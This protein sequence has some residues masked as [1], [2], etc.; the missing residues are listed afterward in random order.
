VIDAERSSREPGLPADRCLADAQRQRL[1]ELFEQ[2]PAS[3][4]VV[5]GDDLVFEMVNRHYARSTR[6]RD[7]LI[8]RRALDAFPQLRDRGLKQMIALVRCTG[9][10]C[11]VRELA[12]DDRW[13]SCVLAPLPG[14][15][16]EIDRVMSLAYEVTEL[17]RACAE[18]EHALE[19]SE[20]L[21]AMLGDDLRHP[22]DAIAADA[23][24]VQRVAADLELGSPAVRIVDA[25]EQIS[26]RIAQLLDLARSAASAWGCRSDQ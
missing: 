26:R 3:I 4:A 9:E 13:W 20:K 24:R 23:R 7:D 19:S 11:V 6:R 22:L 5:R 16:G 10:P 17:V 21:T 2:A 25:A 12:V 8:G 15:R 1:Y 14:E 18:L